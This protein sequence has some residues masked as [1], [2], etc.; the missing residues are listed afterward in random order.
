MQNLTRPLLLFALCALLITAAPAARAQGDERP[1]SFTE[2]GTFTVLLLSDVEDSPYVSPYYNQ[3]LS[4]ILADYPVDLALFLGD[5]LEGSNLLYAIGDTEQNVRRAVNAILKPVTDLGLPFAVLFGEKD[6]ASG[7]PLASQLALYRSYDGC[8]NIAPEQGLPGYGDCFLPVYAQDGEGALLN[9]LLL[10]EPVEEP[11]KRAAQMEWLLIKS[12]AATEANGGSAVPAAL[13]MHLPLPE[14][15]EALELAESGEAGSF[16]GLGAHADSR[17]LFDSEG[18]LLGEINEAPAPAQYAAGLFDMLRSGGNV[19]AAFFGG[20][21][22][23][24]YLTATGGVDLVAVPACSYTA[25]NSRATRG[26]RLLR[27]HEDNVMD[28]DTIF[29]PF[30]AYEDVSLF[31]QIP[32]YLLSTTRIKSTTKLLFLA[33]VA[34]S[35]ICALFIMDARRKGAIPP[36]YEDGKTDGGQ[37]E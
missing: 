2:E 22:S 30:S 31:E 34:V 16:Q 13:F 23:N 20:G 17:Y 9:L 36:P 6:A 21:H 15:Y 28:Y 12:G 19:F 29:V 33:L 25:P 11:E 7:M 1:L 35:G 32:Y 37:E 5:Q 3:A 24:T 14:V 18:V 4:G 8:K 27:F 10:S 26:V